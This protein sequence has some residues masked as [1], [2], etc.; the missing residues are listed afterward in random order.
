[1]AALSKP[2]RMTSKVPI[3]IRLK[4]DMII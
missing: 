3:T 2:L 1:M 4:F